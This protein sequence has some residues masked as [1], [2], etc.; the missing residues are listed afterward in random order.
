M[1]DGDSRPNFEKFKNLTSP[2]KLKGI[3][4][5]LMILVISSTKSSYKIAQILKL[6]TKKIKTVFSSSKNEN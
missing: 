5:C 1:N 4:S 2:S 3:A 6:F